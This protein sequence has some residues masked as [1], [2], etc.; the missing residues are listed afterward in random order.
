[1]I[2]Q[3]K[4]FVL[5]CFFL[6]SCQLPD[7]NLSPANKSYSDEMRNL[8]QKLSENAKSV[9]SNFLVIPQNGIELLKNT[10]GQTNQT[11][12][13][14]INGIAV[15]GMFYGYNTVNQA[16]SKKEA[17]YFEKYLGNTSTDSLPIFAIDYCN[18]LETINNSIL[19][20]TARNNKLFIAINKNTNELPLASVPLLNENKNNIEDLNAAKN[21]MI[22]ADLTNYSKEAV[23]DFISKSNYD[24]VIIDA[25]YKNILL[26][27]KDIKALKLK[28][29]GG[30]RLV[31]A[32]L[33]VQLANIN[34]YYWQ[35]A[36]KINLPKF[37]NKEIGIE[38]NFRVN[39]WDTEWQNILFG[40]ENA[41]VN[42]FV[43]IGFDGT[44]L[45]GIEAY[46]TYE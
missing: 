21:F 8:V 7:D 43:K 11:Y 41:L 35:P 20:N 13:K 15:T 6:V 31:L 18:T 22:I 12:K 9:K 39:Y 34:K 25:F 32:H 26:E 2:N 14:A 19:Q 24:L 46:N 17:A 42:K 33:N 3:G 36:W 16:N 27:E 37:T 28:K 45:T 40:N 29:N 10:E 4:I 44:Y 23:I 1:M 5:F 30:K 38:G